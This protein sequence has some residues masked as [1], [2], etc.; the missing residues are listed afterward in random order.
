VTHNGGTWEVLVLYLTP[1]LDENLMKEDYTGPGP[2]LAWYTQDGLGSVRQLVVGDAVQNSYTYTAWGVPLNWH[3][4]IPNRYTFTGREYNPET[5]LYH[6]R[7]REYVGV[8]GRFNARD[9]ISP[10]FPAYAYS[11]D[12][13]VN[14]VDPSGCR[15]MTTGY[16]EFAL[17]EKVPFWP[18]L[19]KDY[20]KRVYGTVPRETWY[21]VACVRYDFVIDII[22]GQF[23]CVTIKV[24][25]MWK[26]PVNPLT[27]PKKPTERQTEKL[28]PD[29][30]VVRNAVISVS[31]SHSLNKIIWKRNMGVKPEWQKVFGVRNGLEMH[32]E[33][34]DAP[35]IAEC[36]GTVTVTKSR[37]VEVMK[38][39]EKAIK[40][41]LVPE[42]VRVLAGDA[43]VGLDF[44]QA[45]YK[46]LYLILVTCE[47]PYTVTTGRGKLPEEKF[48][49]AQVRGDLAFYSRWFKLTKHPWPIVKP[50]T[51]KEAWRYDKG[52]PD[53]AKHVL[54]K[55]S[56]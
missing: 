49:P 36:T 20:L 21:P 55:T 10:A 19:Y 29:I 38:F 48:S 39:E 5:R 35:T 1:F 7:A 53:F 25:P 22:E 44:Y 11:F 23:P 52:I 42:T 12:N 9:R 51:K 43:K 2:L 18:D 13:P 47:K 3:E 24:I 14:F 27:V 45:T 41:G 33:Y 37:P 26:Q 40:R 30:W 28:R 54:E 32:K 6:Y 15:V 16:Y 50:R 17:F 31:L 34:G 46:F 56:W 8:L 4:S